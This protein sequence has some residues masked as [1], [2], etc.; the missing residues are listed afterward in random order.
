MESFTYVV[1]PQAEQVEVDIVGTM[2]KPG[3]EVVLQE[4]VAKPLV[5]SGKLVVKPTEAPVDAPVETPAEAPMDATM[6]PA[7]V[8]SEPVAPTEAAPTDVPPAA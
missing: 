7:A 5:E 4:D 2:F 3:D 8:P 6:D 1:Q